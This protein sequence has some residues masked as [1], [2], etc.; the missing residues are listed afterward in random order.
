[1][2][3]D[4]NRGYLSEMVNDVSD[5]GTF[6]L[7]YFASSDGGGEKSQNFMKRIKAIAGD[8]NINLVKATEENFIAEVKQADVVHIHGGDTEQLKT[9]L[10]SY[11]DFSEAIKGKTVSGSSAGAYVLT[12]YYFTN[13]QNKVLEGLGLIPARVACHYQ[14]ISHAASEKVDPVAALEKYDNNLEMILLKDC[15]W[16]VR[17]IELD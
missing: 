6:L 12:T 4:L 13:S 5:G 14:S 8:R 1:L 17:E 16:E 15:E 2:E 11:K 3:N 9:K 7:V 10:A